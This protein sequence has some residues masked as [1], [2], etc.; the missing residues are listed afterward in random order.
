MKAVATANEAALIVDETNTGCGASGRGFWMSNGNADYVTFGKRTQLSGFYS[1]ETGMTNLGG[2]MIELAQMSTIYGV[3]TK[4]NL[5]DRVARVGAS[6]QRD[7]AKATDKS[8]RITGSRGVG[9][10]IWI[11]TVAGESGNLR[12]H[13]AAKGVLV[14]ANGNAGIMTKPSLTLEEHQGSALAAALAGF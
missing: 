9:T 5:V 1:S 14:R 4:D 13:L 7:V 3:M 12:A 11:D 2:N 8:S 6:M 10:S